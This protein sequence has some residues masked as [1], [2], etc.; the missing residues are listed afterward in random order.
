MDDARLLRA[1]VVIRR[2]RAGDGGELVEVAR[3]FKEHVPTPEAADAFLLDPR[4]VV[5][6]EGKLDGFLLAYVLSRMDGRTAVFLYELGV[7]EHARRQ[8]MGRRLVEE[9]KRIGRAKDA[10]EMYVLTE[11]DNEPANRLYAAT[12]AEVEAAAM[13]VWKL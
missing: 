1:V 11:P 6:V 3:R 5:F 8:G 2:L 4:H 9:A 7:A 13:W 10:F 12:G